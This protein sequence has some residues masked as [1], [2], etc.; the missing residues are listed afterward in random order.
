MK[1]TGTTNSTPSQW[2]SLTPTLILTSHFAG[3]L[4]I[5]KNKSL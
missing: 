2:S 1:K 4:K 3:V 5:T